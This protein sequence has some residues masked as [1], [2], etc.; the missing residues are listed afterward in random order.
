VSEDGTWLERIESDEI[1]KLV[2]LIYGGKPETAI[3]EGVGIDDHEKII[4]R[5]DQIIGHD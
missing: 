2:E 4:K 3:E 5:V 1:K